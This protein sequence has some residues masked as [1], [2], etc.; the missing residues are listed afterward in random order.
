M[1][2]LTAQALWW[3]AL[4]LL[5]FAPFP[6]YLKLRKELREANRLNWHAS[7]NA[8]L[9][10]KFGP[11][12]TLPI[13]EQLRLASVDFER[14]E[15]EILGGDFSHKAEMLAYKDIILRLAA[16]FSGSTGLQYGHYHKRAIKV[17]EAINK[18]E[19]EMKDKD[20]ALN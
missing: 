1:P 2:T 15:T 4:P 17:I 7:F 16:R 5:L 12:S 19:E 13:D 20:A 14:L 10:M 6:V 9:D 11:G 8:L 3:L 18:H